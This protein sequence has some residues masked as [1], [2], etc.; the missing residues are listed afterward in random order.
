MLVIEDK[1]E[2]TNITD[3]VSYVLTLACTKKRDSCNLSGGKGECGVYQ[4][5]FVKLIVTIK[6]KT[7]KVTQKKN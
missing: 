1:N 4:K 7:N 6:M 5:H 2:V 3:L